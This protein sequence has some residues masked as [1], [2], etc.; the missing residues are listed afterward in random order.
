MTNYGY[1]LKLELDFESAVAEVK[2]SLKEQGFG[3]LFEIDIQAKMKEK[4][5]KDMDEY[6][7]IGACNPSL[8]SKA[9]DAEIE[10][11]LLL[12][13]NVIVYMKDD[14]THVST[15]LPSVAMSFLDNENLTCI[16]DEAEFK[17]KKAIDNLRLHQKVL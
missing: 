2:K 13:C 10:I 1:T 8:A 16:K 7:I 15:V 3:V 9:L 6:T 14:T 11:G 12:P 5:D 17:L 4:L